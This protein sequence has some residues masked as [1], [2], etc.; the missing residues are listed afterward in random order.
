MPTLSLCKYHNKDI[1]GMGIRER[2][3]K[4]IVPPCEWL[5]VKKISPK[6]LFLKKPSKNQ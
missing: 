2:K 4:K 5:S 6:Q 1:K 3:R